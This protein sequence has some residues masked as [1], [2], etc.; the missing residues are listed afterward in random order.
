MAM[1]QAGSSTEDAATTSRDDPDRD[2]VEFDEL[3]P[4]TTDNMPST[5]RQSEDDR[6]LAE[7]PSTALRMSAELPLLPNHPSSDKSLA[8]AGRL[9]LRSRRHKRSDP[10]AIAT[11]PSVFDDPDTAKYYQPRGDWENIHRFDPSARWSWSEEDAIVRKID[12]KIM[13]FTCI[14]FMVLELD[15]ANLTQAVTDNFLEDLGLDTNGS[16]SGYFSC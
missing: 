15:R 10:D 3:A 16:C 11:Q 7:D 1:R 8:P 14:M 9:G 13:L 4:L 2:W 12:Y 6:E 5:Y